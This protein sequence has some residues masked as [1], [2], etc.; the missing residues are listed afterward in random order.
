MQEDEET[1]VAEVA[2]DYFSGASATSAVSGE[3]QLRGSAHGGESGRARG[4]ERRAQAD[5]HIFTYTRLSVKLS[6]ISWTQNDTSI[7]WR[8]S[9]DVCVLVKVSKLSSG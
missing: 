1:G 3:A 4:R 9:T 2:G 7:G 5:R 8:L 6:W